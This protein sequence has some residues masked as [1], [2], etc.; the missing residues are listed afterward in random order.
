LAPAVYGH[1]M[2]VTGSTLASWWRTKV[3]AELKA[4][5]ETAKKEPVVLLK[6]E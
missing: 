1:L 4:G 2:N 5:S 6:Q 3:P